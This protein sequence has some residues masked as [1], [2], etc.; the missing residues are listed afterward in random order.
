MFVGVAA[1]VGQPLHRPRRCES[2]EAALDRDQHE[3]AH[4]DPADAA[5]AGRP[6]ENL[7]IVGVDGDRDPHRVAIPARD[8]EHRRPSAGSRQAPAT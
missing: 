8:L 7:A 2:A 5:R 1:I 3:V 4:G 6:G